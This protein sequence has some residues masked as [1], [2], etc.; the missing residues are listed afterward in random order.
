MAAEAEP[1]IDKSGTSAETNRWWM[2]GVADALFVALVVCIL[3][4]ARNGMLDDPGL[5]WHLRYVDQML[6]NGGFLHQETFC[7]PTQGL[8][9]VTRDWLGDILFR[10][11]YAWGGLAGLAVLTTLVMALVLRLVYS[12]VVAEGIPWQV[13]GFWTLWATLAT[14][15]SWLARP[16]VFTFLG[17]LLTVKICEGY[18]SG[19]LGRRQT[20]W[21]LPIFLLWTNLHGGFLAG[22]VTLAVTWL[23]EIVLA[24]AAFE[25]G[26]RK[27]AWAR[28]RWW[29]LLGAGV[30]LVTLANPYGI[31]LHRWNLRMLADPYIQTQTTVE[32][33]PPNFKAPGFLAVELLVLLFPL[34][35]ATSRRRVSFVALVLGI[36]WLHLGLMS[37]RY[38][39]LWAVMIVPVLAALG[40]GVPWLEQ[41]TR[42]FLP[43]RG[44]ESARTPGRSAGLASIVFAVLLLLVSPWL[45]GLVGHNPK[46]IPAAALDRL[47]GLY[48]GETVFHHLDWGG[49]LTWHGWDLKPRLKIWID[50]RTEVH[51]QKH[52]QEYFD[53]LAGLP[54]WEERLDRYHVDLLCLPRSSNLAQ[55]VA[56]T[57]DWTELFDEQEVV[58]YRRATSNCF[59]GESPAADMPASRK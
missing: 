36:A 33:L 18:H 19:K 56:R 25:D 11:A 24:L 27:A 57:R 49:Y 20:L 13:A 44:A 43:P 58:V 3:A 39:T 28:V 34:L 30:G 17:V 59:R 21:L 53:I 22:L 26:Q 55:Q 40:D 29:M 9:M 46:R 41:I 8:P 7:G 42:R 48:R 14:A 1:E 23:V 45:N 47:L 5:G 35:A 16:N 37:R 51:G 54:G 10:L 6:E 52:T 15:P 50:D 2:P 4:H 38:I 31:G 32:W 12:E